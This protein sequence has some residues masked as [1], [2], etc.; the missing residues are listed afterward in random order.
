M[1]NSRAMVDYVIL[2]LDE[3]KKLDEDIYYYFTLLK[4]ASEKGHPQAKDIL[5]TISEALNEQPMNQN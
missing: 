2:I 3:N 4:S 5:I 1:K